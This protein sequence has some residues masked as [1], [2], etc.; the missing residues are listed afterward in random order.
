MCQD[1]VREFRRYDEDP[2]KYFER[3]EGEHTVTGR[4]SR[5][6]EDRSEQSFLRVALWLTLR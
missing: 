2:Y 1:I 6:E 4:V 3:F 5:E